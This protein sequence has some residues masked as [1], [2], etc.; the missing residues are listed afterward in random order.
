MGELKHQKALRTARL[1][2]GWSI[3]EA[4]ERMSGIR[5]QQLRNLEGA[6]GANRDCRPGRV[7]ADTMLEV[8]RVY[9]PDVGLDDFMGGRTLLRLVAADHGAERSLKRYAAKNYASGAA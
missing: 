4:V 8:I 6:R 2:R 3:G 5:D 1:K 7:Y 9:W